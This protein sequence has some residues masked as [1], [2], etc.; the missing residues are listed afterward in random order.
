MFHVPCC[1][2]MLYF[3]CRKYKGSDRVRKKSEFIYNKFKAMFLIGEGENFA[4]VSGC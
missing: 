1:T 4:M 3:Q 2:G